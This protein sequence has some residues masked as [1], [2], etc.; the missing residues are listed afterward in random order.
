[1]MTSRPS[2][3]PGQPL[4][5]DLLALLEILP[6]VVYCAETHGR[7]C[8]LCVS[9]G[10]FALTGRHPAEF[11]DRRLAWSDLVMPEDLPALQDASREAVAAGHPYT[12][13]YRIVHADGSTRWLHETGRAVTGARDGEVYLE[14]MALEVT[15]AKQA[16]A[17]L[18]ENARQ[19]Y[20]MFD[21]SPV[22]VVVVAPD[23]RFLRVNAAFSA[24]VGYADAELRDRTFAEITHPDHRAQDVRE[25][26]RL[27]RGEIERYETDKRYLHKDGR[28]VWGRAAAALVRD[29]LG[30]A[31]YF[32]T[33]VRDITAR[34][35]TEEAL[36]E[37]EERYRLAFQTSPDAVSLNRMSDGLFVD[38]N[39]GFTRMTGWAYEEIVS[40]TQAAIWHDLRDQHQLT[41]AVAR[42]GVCDNLE[43]VFRRKDGTLFTGLVS[44]RG[45]TYQG[46]PCVLSVTRDITDRKRAE[47]DQRRLERQLQQT[48]K[49]ESLGVLAGGIAHDFN[50]ILMA[51]LGHAEL[52]LTQ[53]SPSSPGRDSLG[54]I[55]TA[56]HRAADLC[57]QMLAYA[58]RTSFAS[59]R[60]DLAA[61]VEEMLHLLQ[62]SI[63]K[64]A[65]LRV[66]AERGLPRIQ[67][68]PSQIRQVVM[69]LAL[70]ASEAIGDRSGVIALSVGAT[71]C[72]QAYLRA[73]E[74]AADLPPGTYLH[75]EV[76]DTGRG[77]TPEVRA[78]IFEP[79]F[80]TKFS[81]RGLGLAAVLGIVRAH[82]GAIEVFTEPGR[83]TT[84]RLLFP[85][86]DEGSGASRVETRTAGAGWHGRGTILLA[87]DEESLRALGARMLERLG[88]SVVTAAD[89]RQAVEIYQQRRADIVLVLL[90]LTMPHLDG[91]Q[92]FAELRRLDPDVRVV[93]ASGYSEGDL[94]ARLSGQPAAGLLQKPYTQARMRE[95]LARL[96]PAAED[97]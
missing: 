60:V 91:V 51:V 50:N 43:T 35:L 17:I 12:C 30:K 5:P 75:L 47:A 83:G 25:V 9:G 86:L 61:V 76:A 44:A 85:A 97:S 96:F 1:M 16:E 27:A 90:D 40:T 95:L 79:F 32:V 31:L 63:S 49:L 72:D 23:G 80:S 18:R 21:H 11:L 19:L 29:D 66:N 46:T 8:L 55:V 13:D 20:V 10:V 24:F 7:R 77:M 4:A 71:R 88:F 92:A 39:E 94:V 56:A 78:R 6:G 28:V 48:Q 57:R 41:E 64:K 15:T 58:G 2:A 54:E 84:F 74:L 26:S 93:L 37:S 82:R 14:A 67:A 36:A 45:M 22:G 33:I 52:A 87:D 65:V 3:E 68:D 73:T 69:N 81:G 38:V 89:G 53:V 34:K 62:A 59:E 42:H 70:N